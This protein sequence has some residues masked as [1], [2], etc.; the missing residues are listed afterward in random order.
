MIPVGHASHEEIHVWYN[1]G[2]RNEALVRIQKGKEVYEKGLAMNIEDAVKH[3]HI[4][5]N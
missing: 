1:N 5:M 4:P 3:L 2:R